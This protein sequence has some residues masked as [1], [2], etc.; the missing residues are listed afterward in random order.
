M[1]EQGLT[2]IAGAIAASKADVVAMSE[3]RN[4]AGE[5]FHNKLIKALSD[6]GAGAFHGHYAGGDVGLVSRWP[7]SK[8]EAVF[9]HTAQ[10]R[11][12]LMAYRVVSPDG[13]PVLVGTGHLDW[14]KVTTYPPRGF[15]G[16]KPPWER[17]H[18]NHSL[19]QNS[20]ALRTYGESSFRDD[21]L[22]AFVAYAGKDEFQGVPVI[23][24]GDFNEP[25]HLDWTEA[26]AHLYDHNG[27]VQDFVNSKMLMAAGFRDSWREV[28]PDPAT[29]PGMTYPSDQAQGT[30]GADQRDRI[31][32]I[33]YR[34]PGLRADRTSL[35]G[36]GNYVVKQE[37]QAILAEGPF[38]LKHFPWPS[39]HKA[40]MTDFGIA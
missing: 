27:V 34:G 31:D 16:D 37:V 28:Y 23:L 19:L 4:Y 21:A 5:D 8:A 32:Y 1:V 29:H 24:A 15:S 3:V 10:D 38:A 22:N 9:D 13:K 20:S 25:S 11:G 7:I 35:V 26:T 39:D 30:L 17:L 2:K 14:L 40:V 6:A 12:S 36:S 18:V 33:Y